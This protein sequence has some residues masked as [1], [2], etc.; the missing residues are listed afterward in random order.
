MQTFGLSSPLT[1]LTVA[2]A[3]F[4]SAAGAWWLT[5]FAV[6]TTFPVIAGELSLAVAYGFHAGCAVLSYVF[7]R[8]KVSETKGLELE[9]M[10]GQ[11]R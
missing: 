9:Q 8:A 2:I 4:G 5:N 6:T 10:V 7:V 1:G 3:L 11:T